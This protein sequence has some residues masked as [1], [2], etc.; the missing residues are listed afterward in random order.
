MHSHVIFTKLDAH[1]YE[2]NYSKGKLQ[3][4]L[5]LVYVVVD[6]KNMD[7][8]HNRAKHVSIAVDEYFITNNLNIHNLS[9]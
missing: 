3:I 1:K 4:N 7:L 8:I 5:L 2:W 9:L 6:F